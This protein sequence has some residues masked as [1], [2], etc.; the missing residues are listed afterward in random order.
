MAGIVDRL[1]QNARAYVSEFVEKRLPGIPGS[2]SWHTTEEAQDSTTSWQHTTES[3][4]AGAEA[5][6]P[7][8]LPHNAE[9]ARCYAVLDLPFGAPM[10]QV[11]KRWKTY[12]RKCHPDLH[13]G[14]AVKQAQATELTQ[15]LNSAHAKIK[16]A[17]EQ[18]RP[19]RPRR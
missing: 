17:W 9:L 6:S 15:Q 19:Q 7:H 10:A 2:S 11:S 18:Y 3:P 16:A 12:L 1:I 13:T 14:D 8:G 5:R 4:P